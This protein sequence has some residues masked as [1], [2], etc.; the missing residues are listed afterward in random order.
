MTSIK[1]HGA[2][3]RE[4]GSS[5]NFNIKTVKEAF[6]A[7]DANNPRFISKIKKLSA[8]GM[9]YAVIVN[10]KK[11]S[12]LKKINKKQKIKEIS[13]VP[14]IMGYGPAAAAAAAALAT[15]ALGSALAAGAIS[16]GTF[17]VASLV[18]GVVSMALQMLLAPKP[19]EP[20]AIE[21]TTRALQDS[22]TFSNKVNL[23]DQGTR[24]PVGYGR[25][26][27]ASNVIEFM[28][29]NYPQNKEPL[30]FYKNGPGGT[31]ASSGSSRSTNP[32]LW[33]NENPVDYRGWLTNMSV[34]GSV[35]FNLDPNRSNTGFVG[36][37]W[38][39]I[40]S[41]QSVGS[42]RVSMQNTGTGF[43]NVFVEYGEGF[44]PYAA[45]MTALS[46]G[47]GS[48]YS[49]FLGQFPEQWKTDWGAG[50]AIQRT[51]AAAGSVIGNYGAV[52]PIDG[53]DKG[54]KG[55]GGSVSRTGGKTMF[56][57]MVPAGLPFSIKDQSNVIARGVVRISTGLTAVYWNNKT[58]SELPFFDP[59]YPYGTCNGRACHANATSDQPGAGC[60]LQGWS[61]GSPWPA[62]DS[63]YSYKP[64]NAGGAGPTF[65]QT[66]SRGGIGPQVTFD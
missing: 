6:D 4:F 2:L 21:A 9:H 30:E 39:G 26:L 52:N 23:A 60:Y 43:V 49:S 3:A 62:V 8:Q 14:A 25:M 5:F 47:P 65:R 44:I 38:Q 35:D 15:A 31:F 28:T 36:G 10:G 48:T 66:S 61:Q 13:I 16:M 27:S 24:V 64:C 20:P 45:T 46:L 18:V 55:Y 12:E 54:F 1:L 17:I 11:L 29:K 32:V 58:F 51:K 57:Y 40:E 7:I 33:P 63:N 37:G 53:L 50:E 41:T 56:M 22:F 59:I 34:I 42:I 19:P